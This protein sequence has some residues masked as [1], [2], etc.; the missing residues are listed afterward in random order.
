[1][2][3]LLYVEKRR[4]FEAATSVSVDTRRSPGSRDPTG[5]R[6]QKQDECPQRGCVLKAEL[7]GIC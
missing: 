6:R 1:M 7:P 5:Q 2:F 3:K 4:L